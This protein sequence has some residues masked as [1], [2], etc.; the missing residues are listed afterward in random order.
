MVEDILINEMYVRKVISKDIHDSN[1][2]NISQP[3]LVEAI[4][5][6]S[7]FVKKFKQLT[8]TENR[9]IIPNNCK[10]LDFSPSGQ[11]VLIIE[12]E[13][14]IRTVSF[15]FD[16]FTNIEVLKQNGKFDLYGLENFEIERPFRLTLSFP[17]IIYF[18]VLSKDNFFQD[19]YLFFRLH[20]F[21]S[22]DDYLLEPCLPNVSEDFRVCLGFNNQYQTQSMD[23]IVRSVI[24][25]FWFNKFN[26]DYFSHC[27]NYFDVPELCDYFTWAYNTKIDPLF[28]FSTKWKNT[29]YNVNQILS[30][31]CNK[32]ARDDTYYLLNVLKEEIKVE[33]VYDNVEKD[34]MYRSRDLCESISLSDGIIVS[35]GDEIKYNDVTFYVDSILFNYSHV[36]EKLFL[37]DSNE[38]KVEI[39]LHDIKELEEICKNLSIEN[40]KSIKIKDDLEI[41]END[42][43]YFNENGSIKIVEK[44]CKCRDN[45]YHIKIGEEFYLESCFLND[46]LKKLTDN[47]KFD[48]EELIVGKEYSFID[49]GNSLSFIVKGYT[50]TYQGYFIDEVRK[51]DKR[52]YLRF[53]LL[54]D[55]EFCIEITS[56]NSIKN[57]KLIK[58]PLLIEDIYCINNKIFT[59]FGPNK[60]GLIKNHGVLILNDQ[61]LPKK[62]S[63][64][65]LNNVLKYNSITCRDYF[66]KICIDKLQSFTIKS[67]D[68]DYTYTFGDEVINIDW[69]NPDDMLKIKTI[70]GFVVDD[71]NFYISLIDES[72]NV[73]IVPLLNFDTGNASF[74]NFRK[75]CREINGIKTGTLAKANKK[76]FQ[77]FL[78]KDQYE[79]KAFVIDDEEPLVLFSNYRTIYFS[80]FER[81]FIIIEESNKNYKKG[82]SETKLVIKVQDGDIFKNSNRKFIV[83]SSESYYTKKY[84]YITEDSINRDLFITR[85]SYGDYDYSLNN[86]SGLLYPR[87]SDVKIRDFRLKKYMPGIHCNMNNKIINNKGIGMRKDWRD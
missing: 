74:E 59:N 64:Y 11:K 2:K 51:N 21:T 53:L 38:N 77:D 16:P 54:N 55:E 72:E 78:L 83:L 10:Y 17:Y 87:Y 31:R 29:K 1:N 5:K 82:I 9:F 62:F 63:F 20:P 66:T 84:E 40:P 68:R 35:V 52:I 33:E 8:S 27:K 70:C 65:E 32:N 14:Q 81:D 76:G 12:E 7:D 34:N 22:L 42:L 67:I 19:M 50:G 48:D 43:V 18:I 37:E 23:Q 6:T 60:V 47:L 28:I 57:Y 85:V 4:M 45:T 75:V 36:P 24:D 25:T 3:Y 80:D 58:E 73:S 61:Y 15:D 79:I 44:I 30:E 26:Y 71:E 49:L 56:Y 46:N 41:K 13:P 86:R 69:S 39:D